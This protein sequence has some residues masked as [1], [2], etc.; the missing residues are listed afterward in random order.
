MFVASKEDSGREVG[1]MREMGGAFCW[2]YIGFGVEGVSF[3]VGVVVSE[4]VSFFV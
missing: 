1:S 4:G 3:V 2:E